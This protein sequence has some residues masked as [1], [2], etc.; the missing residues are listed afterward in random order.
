M[1]GE[2]Q[3][4]GIRAFFADERTQARL[5]RRSSPNDTRFP[6][7]TEG[8]RMGD[9]RSP[10]C[11]ATSLKSRV[12]RTRQVIRAVT[13]PT[14]DAATVTL[15]SVRHMP[16]AAIRA[17]KCSARLVWPFTR[18]PTIRRSQRRSIADCGNP[19]DCYPT[20][21]PVAEARLS[22]LPRAVFCQSIRQRSCASGTQK[23]RLRGV[24]RAWW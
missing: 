14:G 12:L 16:K 11:N 8:S 6:I 10:A 15:T 13:M 22:Y 9:L 1:T 7:N 4:L 5:H 19:P 23:R 17:R 21:A 20:N 3:R 2:G 24:P 18:R